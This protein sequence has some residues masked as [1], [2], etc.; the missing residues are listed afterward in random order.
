MM[1]IIGVLERIGGW[2]FQAKHVR[3]AENFLAGGITRW[4]EDEIQTRLTAERPN[5]SWQAQDLGV[6]GTRCVRRFCPR[7]RTRTSCEVD[8]KDLCARLEDVGELEGSAGEG[9]LV[10]EG[11]SEGELV[12]ELTGFMAYFC[13]ERKN[14]E[15]TVA[16]KL[17]AANFY[18][19][20]WVG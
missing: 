13:A 8:S 4:K 10:R 18:H 1:K 2:R 3:G 20:Q 14:K 9:E 7:L 17:V 11:Y 5:V 16:G 6:G 15:A 19:E 12:E